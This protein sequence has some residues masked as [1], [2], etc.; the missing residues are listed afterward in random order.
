MSERPSVG[1][2]KPFIYGKK[3]VSRKDKEVLDA[4]I[5]T[6]SDALDIA[7]K[8]TLNAPVT[9]FCDSHEALRVIKHPPL[10][11]QNRLHR[12]LIYQKTKKLESIE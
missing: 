2:K 9:I 7:A 10:H 11:K 6:I 5:W 8:E 12:G 1:E 3:R 4:E